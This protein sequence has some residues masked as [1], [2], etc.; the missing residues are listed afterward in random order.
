M[1]LL[2]ELSISPS[3]LLGLLGSVFSALVLAV[4]FIYNNNRQENRDRID[5]RSIEIAK[6]SDDITHL[7]IENENNKTRIKNLEDGHR[8]IKDLIQNNHKETTTRLDT[9]FKF[10]Q[11]S[12]I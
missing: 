10:I 1:I 5:A 8:E 2:E 4:V 7:K 6:N 11:G 9:I 3:L 12:K